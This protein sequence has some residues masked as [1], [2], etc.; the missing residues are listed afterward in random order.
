M[1]EVQWGREGGI[2]GIASAKVQ[3]ITVKP[4]S[5]QE[6][7]YF[8]EIEGKAIKQELVLVFLCIG[9][10]SACASWSYDL[11]R[12]E[13]ALEESKG[14]DRDD[15]VWEYFEGASFDRSMFEEGAGFGD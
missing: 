4:G 3:L 2:S 5:R 11:A 15:T 7:I 9:F 8:S 13:V 10:V 12:E 1:A 14:L 6:R